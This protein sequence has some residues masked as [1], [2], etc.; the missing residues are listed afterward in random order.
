[1]LI[2]WAV[3]KFLKESKSSA[4]DGVTVSKS[5]LDSGKVVSVPSHLQGPRLLRTRRGCVWQH[6]SQLCWEKR[7]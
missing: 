5:L 2:S 1:M 4:D 7:S 3:N 6:C